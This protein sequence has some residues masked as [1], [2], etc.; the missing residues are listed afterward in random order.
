[1]VGLNAVLLITGAWHVPEHYYELIQELESHGT[2]VICERLPT[3]NNAVPPNKT[4]EDDIDFIRDVVS[5]EVVVGTHLT[6]VSHSWG[7]MLASA[8]LASFAVSPESSEGG[9]TD[10][11]FIAAFIPLENDS[12]AGL[13]GGKLPPVLVPQSDGTL[14]PTDPIHL[15]YHDLPEEKAQWANETMVAHGTDAQYAPI[16]CEKVAWRLIPLTYIICEEDQGLLSFLQEGMIQKVEEQG[17]A[18]QKYRLPSSHSPFLSMPDKL[19]ETVLEVMNS[20]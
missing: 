1:M 16:N 7:G 8:A 17:V 19:A 6:V 12:L 3:N 10:M 9:V 15:F 2:R 11:I 18:V 4:I 5:R 13:F 20:R 14:M